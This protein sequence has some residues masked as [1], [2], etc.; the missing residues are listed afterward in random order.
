VHVYWSSN[1][2]TCEAWTTRRNAQRLLTKTKHSFLR[3]HKV[4]DDET[5]EI[6]LVS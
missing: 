3:L 6:E 5:A 1:F 4:M 2:G